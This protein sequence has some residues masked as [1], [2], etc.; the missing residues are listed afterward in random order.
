MCGCQ[1]LLGAYCE[2][3]GGRLSSSPESGGACPEVG[4]VL[5]YLGA[6]TIAHRVHNPTLEGNRVEKMIRR[7]EEKW[8][9]HN[10][11][12]AAQDAAEAQASVASGAR[13]PRHCQDT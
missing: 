8:S 10:A 6:S 13:P 2:L 5:E 1:G 3:R 12:H 9:L 11:L 4:R 7:G